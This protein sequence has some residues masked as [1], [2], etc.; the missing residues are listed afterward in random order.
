MPLA[1]L[2]QSL[3]GTCGHCGQKTGLLQ[4]IHPE[5][6]Q[7]HQISFTEMVQL[8]AQAAGSNT[9]NEAALRQTLGA[10]AQRSRATDQDIDRALEEGFRQGV[11]QAMSDG[12]LT[13]KEEERL[14]AF[15]DSLALEDS[16]ADSKTL[17]TLDRASSGR[18]IMEVSLAAISVHDGAS[19]SMTSA[20]PSGRPAWTPTKPTGSSSGPESQPSREHWR[21][22]WYPSARSQPWQNTPCSKIVKYQLHP[23]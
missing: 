17:A 21:T 6:R 15:R 18:L 23:D 14:R 5:C 10:I 9:F 1:Q 19:T 12:I 11:T 8:S 7:T 22:G 16:S 2:L 13:R 20:Q 4:H 3:T